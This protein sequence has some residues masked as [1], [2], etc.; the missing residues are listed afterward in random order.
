MLYDSSEF[1]LSLLKKP[2][3]P[4]SLTYPLIYVF[5]L[6]LAWGAIKFINKY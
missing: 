3:S 2:P 6:R 5:I 4:P 1:H